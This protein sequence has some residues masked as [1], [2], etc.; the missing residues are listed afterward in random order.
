M[1]LSKSAYEKL[2]QE[3]WRH[4]QLYYVEHRPKISDEEWD[5]LMKKLE[6]ME[7]EHPEWVTSS[8]PSQRVGEVLTK[9]FKTVKHRVPMLSL[10]NTYSKE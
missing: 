3:I 2:C 8:S 5:H 4:N 10:A 6:Q 9:G 7:K 1:T